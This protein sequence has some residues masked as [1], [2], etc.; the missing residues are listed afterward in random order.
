MSDGFD[1]LFNIAEEEKLAGNPTDASGQAS[2]DATGDDT[3]KDTSGEGASTEDT[4]LTGSQSQDDNNSAEDDDTSLINEFKQLTGYEGE[5]KDLS[6][7]GIA[8]VVAEIKENEAKK[9]SVYDSN[10]QIKAV[11]EWVAKG[12]KLEDF[13]QVPKPF[14]RTL[15][16]EDNP[17]HVESVLVS[18]YKDLKNLTDEEVQ[19]QLDFLAATP[20]KQKARFTTALDAIEANATAQY[21]AH[22]DKVEADRAKALE[23]GKK[24]EEVITSGKFQG[25]TLTKEETT[26]FYSFIKDEKAYSAKWESLDKDPNKIA[27]LEYL[28]F[29]DFDLSKIKNFTPIKSN[30]ERKTPNLI[31]TSGEVKNPKVKMSEDEVLDSLRSIKLN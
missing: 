30:G 21:Q 19:E 9:Y 6:V 1:K 14:D 11:A 10:P 2:G 24:L 23:D 17:A 25:L 3:S 20:D 18:Y 15:Y 29:N 13:L 31:R 27:L 7:A 22:I 16:K 26:A 5:V 12:G 4:D 8:A 28:V